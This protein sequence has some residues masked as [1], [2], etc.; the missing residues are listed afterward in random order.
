MLASREPGQNDPICEFSSLNCLLSSFQGS[1][2]NKKA[3]LTFIITFLK[4]I[5]YSCVCMFAKCH[6]VGVREQLGVC[7]LLPPYG[8]WVLVVILVSSAFTLNQLWFLFFASMLF[9]RYIKYGLR[10][11]MVDIAFYFSI[12]NI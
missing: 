2:A 5:I 7:S 9:S 11:I 12:K 10:T 1:I 4:C 8:Y 3:I 6:S